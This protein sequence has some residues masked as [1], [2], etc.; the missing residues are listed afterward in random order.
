MTPKPQKPTKQPD[1]TKTI[2]IKKDITDINEKL[3]YIEDLVSTKNSIV[4]AQEEAS[5]AM[6]NVTELRLI[7]NKVVENHELRIKFMENAQEKNEKFHEKIER[8]L[9]RFN[10]RFDKI[11]SK[12]LEISYAVTQFIQKRSGDL[13]KAVVW[14]AVILFTIVG[15][16]SF[17]SYKMAEK[18]NDKGTEK[19]LEAQNKQIEMLIEKNKT[20]TILDSL[21]NTGIAK[22]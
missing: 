18:L 21:K 11:E 7:N 2:E 13:W 20:S 16:N 8:K 9:D 22:N 3:G 12:V 4:F 5:K 14:I 19:L 6:S 10:D 15:V 17:V 1:D